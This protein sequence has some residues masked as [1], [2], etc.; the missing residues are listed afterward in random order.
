MKDLTK[1]MIVALRIAKE[2][3]SVIAGRNVD[4]VGRSAVVAAS[5][6][7]G[8]ERRGLVQLC[9][10]TEGGMG[11]RLTDLGRHTVTLLNS[12]NSFLVGV[13]MESGDD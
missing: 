3:G 6:L 4:R 13:A 10:D 12:G 7:R 1:P 2:C 11:A 9:L 5:V 8:L